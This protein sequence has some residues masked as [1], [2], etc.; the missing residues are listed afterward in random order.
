MDGRTDLAQNAKLGW[1]A[2]LGGLS[3]LIRDL[4]D[5]FQFTTVE[6]T[7]L[8]D[9]TPVMRLEGVWK[10]DRLTTLFRNSQPP[11]KSDGPVA[12]RLPEHLPDRVVLFLGRDDLFPFRVEYRRSTPQ[13]LMRGAEDDS[14]TVTMD[15][16]MAAFNIPLEPSRFTFTPGN[17]EHSDQTDRFLERLGVGKK[18]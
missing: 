4:R 6:E 11:S 7:R 14:A 12:S 3:E 8:P 13:S 15:L 17:L 16:Y 9:K 10:P 5:W 18:S 2:R 1:W